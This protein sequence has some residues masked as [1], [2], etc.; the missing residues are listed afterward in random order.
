MIRLFAYFCTAGLLILSISA[1]SSPIVVHGDSPANLPPPG[2]RAP[3]TTPPDPGS[4]IGTSKKPLKTFAQLKTAIENDDRATIVDYLGTSGSNPD[5]CGESPCQQSLLSLAAIQ[6]NPDLLTLL[7][8][9]NANPEGHLEEPVKPLQ[10]ALVNSPDQQF[11]AAKILLNSNNLAEKNSSK[12]IYC[13]LMNGTLLNP[14]EKNQ[15]ALLVWQQEHAMVP[16]CN[17]DKKNDIWH[18]LSINFIAYA[19]VLAL[20]EQHHVGS[21]LFGFIADKILANRQH[22]AKWGHFITDLINKDHVVCAMAYGLEPSP[23]YLELLKHVIDNHGVGVNLNCSNRSLLSLAI[24]GQQQAFVQHII[25]AGADVNGLAVELNKPIDEALKNGPG[26]NFTIAQWLLQGGAYYNHIARNLFSSVFTRPRDAITAFLAA[27]INIAVPI[28]P[29]HNNFISSLEI[30]HDADLAGLFVN[31]AYVLTQDDAF[32][33]IRSAKFNMGNHWK[34]ALQNFVMDTQ[35][36]TEHWLCALLAQ[37]EED[38][39]AVDFLK[40]ALL[41]KNVSPMFRC[42]AQQKSLVAMIEEYIPALYRSEFLDV[43]ASNP[44]ADVNTR[45][46]LSCELL[47]LPESNHKYSAVD[48]L[49][50]LTRINPNF[51]CNTAAG[52]KPILEIPVLDWVDLD[53]GYKYVSLFKQHMTSAH[54]D[55]GLSD[56]TSLLWRYFDLLKNRPSV[57]LNDRL[58]KLLLKNIPPQ[59]VSVAGKI[60]QHIIVGLPVDKALWLVANFEGVQNTVLNFA[61]NQK[62]TPLHQVYLKMP[63]QINLLNK[64]VEYDYLSLI[65]SNLISYGAHINELD[66]NNKKPGDYKPAFIA[67]ATAGMAAPSELSQPSD[68]VIGNAPNGFNDTSNNIDLWSEARLA[69]FTKSIVISSLSIEQKSLFQRDRVCTAI[70]STYADAYT[71]ASLDTHPDRKCVNHGHEDYC[72]RLFN[73]RFSVVKV[74]F[75]K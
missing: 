10:H 74:C 59:Q 28:V 65:A 1:C 29:P 68:D 46:T 19:K 75:N 73:A 47:M 71:E 67:S 60:L 27:G 53:S 2:V 33:V 16:I 35:L 49:L 48:K 7:V 6:H 20:R 38:P 40:K 31:N 70:K 13:S 55:L 14:L 15:Q 52:V 72:K 17:A 69:A 44:S 23:Q 41:E 61:D 12:S 57:D 34:R 8:S 54:F 37:G 30:G 11:S 3:N 36:K 21:E 25:T 66:A 39:W 62:R 5:L 32:K 50:T 43:I 18:L 42:Q 63:R 56:Q 58:F 51:S 26:Q 4:N 22:L 24:R 64:P 9:N 45:Q